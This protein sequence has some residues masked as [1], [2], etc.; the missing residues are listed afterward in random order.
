MPLPI[1]QY[2]YFSF[3]F[4]LLSLKTEISLWNNMS[5]FSMLS[6]QKIRLYSYFPDPF[7]MNSNLILHSIFLNVLKK[8]EISVNT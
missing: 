3:F 2:T 6:V 7:N 4:S 5:N 8:L 1:S